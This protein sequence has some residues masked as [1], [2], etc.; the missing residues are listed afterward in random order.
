MIPQRSWTDVRQGVEAVR[1]K[2]EALKQTAE[3]Q[4][5]STGAGRQELV[6]RALT[7][8]EMGLVRDTLEKMNSSVRSIDGATVR[9]GLLGV[10]RGAITA[11]AAWRNPDKLLADA[12]AWIDS[13]QN[14]GS[15]EDLAPSAETKAIDQV[16]SEDKSSEPT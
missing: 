5:V 12:V 1:A 8:D 11:Y 2:L 10:A 6:Q 15:E 13:K 7:R 14:E 16:S 4:A 3:W 9:K